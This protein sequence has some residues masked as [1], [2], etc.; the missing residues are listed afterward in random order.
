VKPLIRPGSWII[1]VGAL[2]SEAEA[3]T[4]LSEARDHEQHELNEE[5]PQKTSYAFAAFA[6]LSLACTLYR[7]EGF[8]G[9][10]RVCLTAILGLAP[11]ARARALDAAAGYRRRVGALL[12]AAISPPCC[13]LPF[14]LQA[15]VYGER[16]V[17]SPR[18]GIRA[19]R[20]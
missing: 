20:N 3:K 5:H 6:L 12:L 9:W 14:S 4:R 19:I 10:L 16:T 1:Q 7:A 15:I 13:C 18:C 11:A 8:D 2:E 17:P